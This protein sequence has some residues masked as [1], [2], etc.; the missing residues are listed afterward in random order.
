M[1]ATGMAE[2]APKA[3]P[4]NVRPKM[5][6]LKFKSDLTAGILEIHVETIKPCNRKHATVAHQAFSIV[7]SFTL[8]ECTGAVALAGGPLL[9]IS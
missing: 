3:D 1:P 8:P 7:E 5:P 4:S 6:L 2:T 9:S